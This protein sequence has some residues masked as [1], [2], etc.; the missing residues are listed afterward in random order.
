MCT[1]SFASNINHVLVAFQR[2]LS[3]NKHCLNIYIKL[4]VLRLYLNSQFRKFCLNINHEICSAQVYIQ[5]V[6]L[7]AMN[8]AW[9]SVIKPVAL[10]LYSDY[11]FSGYKFYLNASFETSSAQV[12]NQTANLASTSSNW[13]LAMKLIALK[14]IFKY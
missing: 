11:K 5:T 9:A 1:K 12:Y 4:V 14:F 13:T 3:S 7:A 10:G 8:S 6:N 2:K